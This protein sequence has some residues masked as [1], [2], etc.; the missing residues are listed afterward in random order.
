[1]KKEI[2]RGKTFILA[3]KYYRNYITIRGI[4]CFIIDQSES[5][6]CVNQPITGLDEPNSVISKHNHTVAEPL[7]G[8]Y[9]MITELDNRENFAMVCKFFCC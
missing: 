9:V 5:R 8:L 1:M 6:V 4:G 3:A 7:S 2:I